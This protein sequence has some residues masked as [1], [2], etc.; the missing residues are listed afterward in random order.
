MA[1]VTVLDAE[2]PS[3]YPPT[4]DARATDREVILARVDPTTA[5]LLVFNPRWGNYANYL[6]LPTAGG[7]IDFRRGWVSV[8]AL[9]QGRLFRFISTHLEPASSV[10]QV[11][12]ANELLS[13]PANVPFP[14]IMLG[15]FN[16]AAD[17]STTRT[18]ATL[19]AGGFADAWRQVLPA[20]P[21]Y[22]CCH[23]ANLLEP[24]PAL[25]QR[26]DL[27]MSRG[28]FSAIRADIV[29]EALVDRTPTGLW[30][31]DHAGVIAT[32]QLPRSF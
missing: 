20:D 22:T 1:V 27:I 14:V 26:I 28:G 15:D 29:G 2:V 23:A 9:L 13:G 25:S 16:S 24:G 6:S 32:L 18:Y 11:A 8:D 7:P 5:G 21:G 30:P 17:G 31:S 10:I 4:M 12:Q 3:G 19:T